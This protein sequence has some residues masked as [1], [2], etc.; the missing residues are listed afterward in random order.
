MRLEAYLILNLSLWKKYN[1]TNKN[2]IQNFGRIHI[3]EGF[4]ILSCTSFPVNQALTLIKGGWSSHPL[5]LHGC[6]DLYALFTL[7]FYLKT[8]LLLLQL[9]DHN[10]SKFG[11]TMPFVILPSRKL[12]LPC[13]PTIIFRTQDELP[14][15][16]LENIVSG[17]VW[18]AH[19]EPSPVSLEHRDYFYLDSTSALIQVLGT[20]GKKGKRKGVTKAKSWGLE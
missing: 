14:H 8:S 12:S 6:S 11:F 7:L 20:A 9:L 2:L 3:S 10:F 1:T 18:R 15:E 19:T 5:A 13:R 17:S 16:S 4:W